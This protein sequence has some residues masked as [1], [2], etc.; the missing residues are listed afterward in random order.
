[1]LPSDIRTATVHVG[2]FLDDLGEP[3]SGTVTVESST[4]RVWDATAA[5]ISPRPAVVPLG[6]DG[7]AAIPLATTDQPGF[8]DGAGRPVTGWTY[9]LT[10]QLAGVAPVRRTFDLPTSTGPDLRLMLAT[11]GPPAARGLTRRDALRAGAAA[12]V[13]GTAAAATAPPAAA[14]AH[15]RGGVVLPTAR[16]VF[17]DDLQVGTTAHPSTLLVKSSPAGGTAGGPGI[18]DSTGRI[19]LETYQPHFGSYG[20]SLRVQLKDARAKGMLTYQGSWP[21]P[22]YPD[23]DYTWLS[24]HPTTP[25]TI[26]WI[27][28]H[29]L[30]NDDPGSLEKN[31]WHGHINFEVPDAKGALRTRLEIKLVDPVTGKIGTDRS[32]VRTHMADFELQVGAADEQ[33]RIVGT[34]SHP[35]D[36]VFATEVG[37][38]QPRWILRATENDANLELRRYRA[39][40]AYQDSPVAVDRLTGLVAVGGAAGTSAGLKVAQRGGVGITVTPL[41]AGGQGMLVAGTDPTA[42]VIQGEV[43]GDPQR[44]FVALVDGTLGWGTGATERDTLLYRRGPN[45]L[46]TDGGLFLRSSATPATATTGG[47]LFVAD[48]ALKYRGAAGTV[49]T[50]AAA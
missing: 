34:D 22:H 29:F 33:L 35:K 25:V 44:R 9:T 18:Y 42:R 20:E 30:N 46:G 13:A 5:V 23:G 10:V 7:T 14:G 1:M 8:S 45:Q 16:T 4:A 19:V 3:W 28:A 6:G 39:G 24:T 26:A 38:R 48:G 31:L 15:L 43:T 40:N 37:A 17:D 11:A 21:T 41:A 36:L 50:L 12:L 2:P 49:T 32:A 47:V 27:G